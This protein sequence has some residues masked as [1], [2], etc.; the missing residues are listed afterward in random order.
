MNRLFLLP[1]LAVVGCGPL[2]RPI[3]ER[4]DDATQKQID[5]AWDAALAPV[6]KHDRQTWLDVFV[7]GYAHEFGIDTLTFRS[8]KRFVGGKVVMEVFY[9]RAKPAEDRF[10]VTVYDL[11]GKAV[12]QER[13]GREEVEATYKDFHDP[14]LRAA[15][16]PND[17]PEIQQR[18]AALEGR[19]RRLEG[20]L[21]NRP[22]ENRDRK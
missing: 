3:P 12:R 7:T 13:Y 20:I 17:P 22:E 14:Q 5:A 9:D 19:M 8:E 1:A 10:V 4:P 21:P 2:S 6:G 11:A 18:R 16:G 15:A